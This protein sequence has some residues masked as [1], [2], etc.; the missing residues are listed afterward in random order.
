MI[1]YFIGWD[2]GGWNCD[3]NNRSRDAVV[4]LDDQ[5]QIVGFPWRG[6]MRATLNESTNTREWIYGLFNLCRADMP[7]DAFAVTMGIDTPLGFSRSFLDLTTTLQ[8]VAVI[9]ESGTN[10]Y[11]FRA[12]ERFLFGRGITPLSAIKDMIGSQATKGMHA[13]ARFAP[14]PVT[15]GVWSDSD[16]L[17][18]IEA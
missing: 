17:T 8:P 6:N 7:S 13:L 11:L 2:V 10:P 3:R 15:C 16:F 4:I 1:N 9:G 12:T 5:L 18:A 14:N